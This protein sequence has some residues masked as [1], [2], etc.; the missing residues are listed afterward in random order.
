MPSF[1][2]VSEIDKHELTNAIDQTN[3]EISTRYDFKG[4]DAK[5]DLKDKTMT[6]DATGDFQIKQIH[7]VMYNKLI[8]RGIDTR[9]LDI[10]KIQT[11]GLRVAQEIKV[12]EGIDKEAAKKNR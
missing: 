1:D 3:R 9:C 2:V 10:G 11:K 6:L 7:D 5:I 12:R 4:S 8:K